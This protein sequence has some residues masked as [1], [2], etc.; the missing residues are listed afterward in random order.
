MMIVYTIDF[1]I[2]LYPLTKA[3]VGNTSPVI[4]SYGLKLPQTNMVFGLTE[5]MVHHF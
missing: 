1:L 3:K 2:G 4:K 5:K